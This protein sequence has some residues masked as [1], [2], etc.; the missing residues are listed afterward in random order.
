MKK[1]IMILF[2]ILTLL[3]PLTA[4]CTGSVETGSE[5][6]I[7]LIDL[8]IKSEIPEPASD[9]GS[10]EK[11][12]TD[13]TQKKDETALKDSQDGSTA[14]GNEVSDAIDVV[15]S[16]MSMDE[17]ISQMIIPAIRTWNNEPV[18]D[19]DKCPE[20]KETLKKHRYGGIILFAPNITDS[21]QA[22]KLL[23]DLNENNKL[24]DASVHIPYFTP[25]DEE[26]G[27]VVRLTDGTRMTGNMAIGA[28]PDAQKNAEQTGT[29]LGDELA[30][31]GFNTDY[32]P[33]VDVNNNPSNPVIGT[34]S[35]SDDPDTVAKLGQAYA[36]GL[37][38]SNV[39]AVYKHFPGHGDTETDSH[40]GTPCLEKT[41]EEISR[42]ELVPFKAAIENGA[43]MIM[44][45]HITFPLIDDEVTFGDGVT[46]GYYPA[47]MSEKIIS[48]I[49]RTDLGFDGVV[50]SD[51][52]EMG[53]I[54]SAGLV[55]GDKNSTEY[56]INIAEKVINA[57]VDILLLPADLKSAD[58]ALFYD[59]YIDGIAEKVKSGEIRPERIDESVK[60]ILL[61]KAKY[62]IFDVSGDNRSVI[63]IE[64][65]IN[66]AKSTVGSDA[67]REAELG[68][69][70]EAVTVV[71]NENGLLPLSEAKKNIVLFGRLETDSATLNEAL[72][73]LKGAGLIG[74][75]SGISADFYYYSLSNGTLNY[76]QEMKE[77][78][79]HADAVIG[80]SYTVGTTVLNKNGTHYVALK[81]AMEDV[82]NGGGKFILLSENLPYDSAVFQD[83]DAI[84]LSYMGSDPGRDP[85]RE[86]MSGERVITA[87]A[88]VIAA[89]ETIFGLNR[90]KGKLPV[91]IPVV[92]TTPEGSLKYGDAVLYERG[93]GLTY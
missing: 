77:K 44:T 31:I 9:A 5:K 21:A 64:D 82:H 28:T 48:G 52:L 81:S 68:I 50:V 69:A 56:Q 35:F 27:M 6:E 91:N 1:R 71:K 75:E 29:I 15:I 26:G 84:V 47:T 86:T 25:V 12:E 45:A 53:A 49:L 37:K 76:T 85:T 83:A 33:D 65:K 40:T 80:L 88:N 36:A 70:R 42:T 2:L 7:P 32:A 92:E 43:D 11:S 66:E 57:G 20:L 18:T 13:E 59:E 61:L 23:Y 19:L 3:F 72:D 34:R 24:S 62:G 58:A 90:P 79:S 87:N 22:T 16:N 46:R 60:R 73:E 30:A 10:E 38:K 51:A 67:H 78:I 4:G 14:A 63:N 8:N 74:G 89:V 93:F 39:I 41:Y 55:G 54:R 17:K